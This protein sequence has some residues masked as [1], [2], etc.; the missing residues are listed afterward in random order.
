M[1][2]R[3]LQEVQAPRMEAKLH[4]V[5]AKLGEENA[6]AVPEAA[7]AE[8]SS[9]SSAR[10]TSWWTD[11]EFDPDTVVEA[12]KSLS[13]LFKASTDGL[14]FSRLQSYHYPSGQGPIWNGN[15]GL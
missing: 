1:H 8:S 10:E 7:V 15:R 4:R 2:A 11:N 13:A 12:I 6:T 5:R 9:A 14:C 3:F